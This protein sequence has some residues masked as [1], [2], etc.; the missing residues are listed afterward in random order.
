[1]IAKNSRF[2][3]TPL[4]VRPAKGTAK[5]ATGRLTSNGA[6]QNPDFFRGFQF[7]ICAYQGRVYSSK[8][9]ARSDFQLFRQAGALWL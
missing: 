3:K 2:G 6:K 4:E 7:K 1:M 9:S 5:A 8:I